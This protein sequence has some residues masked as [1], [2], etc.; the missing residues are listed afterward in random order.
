MIDAMAGCVWGW[1]RPSRVDGPAE[2]QAGGLGKACAA[3]RRRARATSQARAVV[4]SII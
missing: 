4:A 3:A 2:G 1:L